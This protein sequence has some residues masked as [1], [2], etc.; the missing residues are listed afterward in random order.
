[1]EVRFIDT[2]KSGG[3]LTHSKVLVVKSIKESQFALERYREQLA[4]LIDVSGGES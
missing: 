2:S 4:Q 3:V 1:M